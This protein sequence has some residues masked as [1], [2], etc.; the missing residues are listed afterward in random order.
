MTAEKIK[1]DPCR[2]CDNC[3][4]PINDIF[5]QRCPR[6]FTPLKPMVHSCDSCASKKTCSLNIDSESKISDKK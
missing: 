3:G 4:L 2:K 1:Q 6:C 5:V